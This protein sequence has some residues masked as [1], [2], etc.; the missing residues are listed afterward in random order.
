VGNV[1]PSPIQN[2]QALYQ[3]LF[4]TEATPGAGATK[5]ARLYGEFMADSQRSVIR[6]PQMRRAYGGLLNPRRG[7]FLYKPKWK[8]SI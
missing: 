8:L 1:T 7:H 4:G 6:K 5:T 3:V 2:D